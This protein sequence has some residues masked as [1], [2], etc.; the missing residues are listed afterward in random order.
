MV[1]FAVFFGIMGAM[2]FL[3]AFFQHQE[4]KGEVKKLTNSR[5]Q[6]IE[7]DVPQATHLRIMGSMASKSG[8]KSK[9]WT[10]K[11]GHMGFGVGLF[12]LVPFFITMNDI[13]F[14]IAA[15]I[16][17]IVIIYSVAIWIRQNPTRPGRPNTRG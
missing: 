16:E 9:W 3:L 6:V 7:A 10:T 2:A 1:G 13:F 8:E 4:G 11:W 15:S 5:E 12:M 17:A 14:Y